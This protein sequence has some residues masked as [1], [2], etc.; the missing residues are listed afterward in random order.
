MG[1]DG[2]R[3][4]AVHVS[5]IRLNSFIIS[6]E[7]PRPRALIQN[8]HRNHTCSDWYWIRYPDVRTK[9]V[10]MVAANLIE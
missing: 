5:S 3:D 4:S 8:I 7:K 6:A 1:P 9:K 2:T 10:M